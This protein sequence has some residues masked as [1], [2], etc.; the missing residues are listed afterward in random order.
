MDLFSW[1]NFLEVSVLK[2]VPHGST[3]AAALIKDS[4]LLVTDSDLKMAQK[5]TGVI[6]TI[7]W[8]RQVTEVACNFSLCLLLTEEGEVWATGSDDS[9]SGL[10]GQDNVYKSESPTKVDFP[11]HIVKVALG[12]THAASIGAQGSLYTWG[13]G[14]HGELGDLKLY[15]S[16]PNIVNS[17]SFFKS[18]DI[19]CGTRSTVVCSEAGLL[20]VFGRKLNCKNCKKSNV[21][22]ATLKALSEDFCVKSLAFGEETFV[23]N[24]RGDIKII[25]QCFCVQTLGNKGKVI[26]FA[27]FASG[28]A[29]LSLNSRMIFVYK[30]DKKGWNCDNFSIHSGQVASLVS[31]NEK[32]IGIIGREINSKS[33]KKVSEGHSGDTSSSTND[34]VS[35]EDIVQTCGFKV[36]I[37][38]INRGQIFFIFERVY[39]RA[40][41][42]IFSLI[43]RSPKRRLSSALVLSNRFF[44][45]SVGKYWNLWKVFTIGYNHGR[46]QFS[47]NLKKMQAQLMRKNLQHLHHKQ[48]RSCIRII[49]NEP[50]GKQ[51]SK[52]R[53][54]YLIVQFLVKQKVLLKIKSFHKFKQVI[55]LSRPNKSHF[56]IDPKYKIEKVP[57]LDE[58]DFDKSQSQLTGHKFLSEGDLLS[59]FCF[60]S[61]ETQN[62]SP[63]LSTSMKIQSN[64]SSPLIE[65]NSPTSDSSPKIKSMINCSS[66]RSQMSKRIGER[67]PN[68]KL[69]SMT[70]R[71]TVRS[72][73][74]NV[75][76]Q[77]NKNKNLTGKNADSPK[78]LTKMS[79]DQMYKKRLSN[80]NFEKEIGSETVKKLLK[81]VLTKLI[82]RRLNDIVDRVKKL[83]KSLNTGS[84]SVGFCGSPN[85]YS[86]AVS[87]KSKLYAL[88]MNKLMKPLGS[89]LTKSYKIGFSDI[90]K[91]N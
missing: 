84:K 88:G 14:H 83:S 79:F 42:D 86:A 31:T 37:E 53:F 47:Q 44:T 62:M 19:S 67:I 51:L 33:L 58:K 15:N 73:G 48:L 63:Q 30:K 55:M 28:V 1:E 26:N 41:S 91:R 39:L 75:T 34:R 3:K 65:P 77:P 52:I 89:L 29:A 2:L 13:T 59:K 70:D 78:I 66:L 71:S 12:S 36:R 49:A 87:W 38:S 16:R 45:K 80:G 81:D 85:S 82:Q 20:F 25:N 9:R 54:L 60:S 8:L 5:K 27:T 72:P 22:P 69:G 74:S 11:V 64:V 4:W 68:I 23:V 18:T 7:K 76:R 56:F 21:Y 43:K 61:N 35:F 10:F 32:S 24:D 46:H 50:S 57:P 6:K 90:S 40:I 17:A